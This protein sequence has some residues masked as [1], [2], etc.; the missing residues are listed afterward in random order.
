MTLIKTKVTIHDIARE[1]GLSASTVSR[2]LNGN[3]VISERTRGAVLAKA[4]ELDYRP[5]GMA[6][7]LRSGRSML[8]GVVIPQANRAFF[9]NIINGVEAV[10]AEGGYRV[11]VMQHHNDSERE[12]QCLTD[13]ERLRVDGIVV[14]VANDGRSDRARY[15]EL[16]ARGTPIHFVDRVIEGLGAPSVVV[17]DFSGARLATE[18]LL[19]GGYRRIAHLRGPRHLR[20]YADRDCGYRA[21][22]SAAGVEADEALVLDVASEV[23]A[24]RAAFARLFDGSSAP[25]DAVFSA[26]DFS[27]LGV[28]KAAQDRGIA[29]GPALGIVGFAN[30]PFTEYVTPG[31]TSVEQHTTDMGAHAARRLLDRL[32][33]WDAPTDGQSASLVLAPQLIERASSRREPAPY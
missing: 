24:G 17:D 18:H 1:L 8:L 9:A 2:A 29:V 6:S 13:L 23:D 25:P 27:A 22:L 11:L 3:A 21:A 19:A 12:I 28:L 14:S 33:D 30:E 20:I 26:S 15:R 31:L 16:L 10:A 7:A 5:N 4:Q 32:P